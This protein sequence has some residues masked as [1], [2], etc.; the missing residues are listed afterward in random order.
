MDDNQ[1]AVFQERVE[2]LIPESA[3]EALQ[4]ANESLTS[5]GQFFLAAIEQ[6]KYGG[7]FLLDLASDALKSDHE[8][9]LSAVRCDGL[10]LR[11]ASDNL[12]SD[13]EI[14][15]A[16][17][18]QNYNARSYASKILKDDPEVVSAAKH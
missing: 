13:R 1:G 14:V 6:L 18:R 12:K 16:A 10:A 5:N 17:V 9:M 3:S 15:L 11:Y 8:F 7:V 4:F 2:D